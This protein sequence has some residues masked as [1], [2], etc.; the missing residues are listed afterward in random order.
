MG[1]YLM[2]GSTLHVTLTP[3]QPVTKVIDRSR[4][5]SKGKYRYRY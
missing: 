2:G 5:F 4:F 1:R 3:I